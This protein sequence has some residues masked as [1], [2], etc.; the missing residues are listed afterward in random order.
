MYPTL[1]PLSTLRTVVL[2]TPHAS[3]STNVYPSTWC[4]YVD[5]VININMQSLLSSP[6]QQQAMRPH[7]INIQRKT[8]PLLGN[9]ATKRQQP[10][11]QL[12]KAVHNGATKC[13]NNSL[14][15]TTNDVRVHGIVLTERSRIKSSGRNETTITTAVRCA[16]TLF[17]ECSGS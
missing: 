5:I 7:P 16:V 3:C 14:T 11:E 1:Q 12:N 17:S 8:K 10:T 6:D 2:C 13:I 4:V 9:D 15:T